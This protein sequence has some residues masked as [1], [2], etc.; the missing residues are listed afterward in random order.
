DG[1]V[2]RASSDGGRDEVH[3]SNNLGAIS[4]VGA[5]I[6]DLPNPGGLES[7]TATEVGGCAD[8][9]GYQTGVAIVGDDRNGE[10]PALH[11]GNGFVLAAV[12]NRWRGVYDRNHL[13][14][15]I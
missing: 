14:A 5:A 6:G 7:V 15:S 3:C 8:G 2:G 1:Q 9:D 11:A 12:D 4:N 10:A 13:I